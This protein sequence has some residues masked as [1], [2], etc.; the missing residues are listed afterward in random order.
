MALENK[1]VRREKLLAKSMFYLSQ[2]VTPEA[3]REEQEAIAEFCIESMLYGDLRGKLGEFLASKKAALKKCEEDELNGVLNGWGSD[4]LAVLA[5]RNDLL[6]K[7]IGQL[8][9]ILNG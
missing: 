2:K 3:K 8:E 7:D 9:G 5:E 1:V 4:D 6:K